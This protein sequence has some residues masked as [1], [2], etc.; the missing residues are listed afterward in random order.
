M[1]FRLNVT[2][3]CTLDFVYC[4]PGNQKHEQLYPCRCIFQLWHC[5]ALQLKRWCEQVTPHRKLPSC[6][7]CIFPL[8]ISQGE[9]RDGKSNLVNLASMNAFHKNWLPS[10]LSCFEE[11]GWGRGEQ[12]NERKKEVCYVYYT[13]ILL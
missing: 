11:K 6:Q 7:I 8:H 3:F 13:F 4:R 1:T 5:R 10:S 12:L 9:G 2:I